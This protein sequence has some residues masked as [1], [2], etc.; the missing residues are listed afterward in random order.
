MNTI[1]EKYVEKIKKL[2]LGLPSNKMADSGNYFILR[3]NFFF[4]INFYNLKE[5]LCQR[6]PL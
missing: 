1:L 2:N 3:Y 6:N 5:I 4:W